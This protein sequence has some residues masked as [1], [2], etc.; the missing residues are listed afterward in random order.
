MTHH[1]A[2]LNVATLKEPPESAGN[3]EFFAVL[4]AVNSIAEVSPGF[5]W[6]LVDES[7]RSSAYID[8]GIDPR[9]I[10]N[11]SVWQSVEALRHY[12]YRSGHGSYFR[13]RREWFESVGDT[14]SVVCWWIEEGSIPTTDDAIERLETLRREG[15]SE[16][17][18]LISD[19]WPMPT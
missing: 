2:Q 9:L 6:R 14:P 5:V 19:P 12:A 7:G 3:A 15:P 10:I 17:G 11:M 13:R 1:L 16:R 18:F 8:S 4:D